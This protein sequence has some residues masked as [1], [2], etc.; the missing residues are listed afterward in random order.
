MN[1]DELIIYIE[2]VLESLKND[3][4]DLLKGYKMAMNDVLD[5]IKG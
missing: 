3:K 5:V 1:N 2:T 4:G